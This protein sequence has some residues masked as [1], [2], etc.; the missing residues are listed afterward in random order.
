MSHGVIMQHLEIDVSWTEILFRTII[1]AVIMLGLTFLAIFV[2]DVAFG[3]EPAAESK[4]GIIGGDKC[5][6]LSSNYDCRHLRLKDR[7]L[8]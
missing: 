5:I 7:T 4:G 8:L 2:Y 6:L 3:A 1:L